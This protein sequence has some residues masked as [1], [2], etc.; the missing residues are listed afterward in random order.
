MSRTYTKPSAT[1]LSRKKSPTYQIEESSA[2]L[3]DFPLDSPVT[4][5]AHIATWVLYFGYLAWR[6][7]LIWELYVPNTVTWS[8]LWLNVLMEV[9]NI[10]SDF[11]SRFEIL[12]YIP[13]GRR[14]A[15]R[16]SYYL[17]GDIAPAVDICITCCGEDLDVIMDTVAGAA[18][19]SY[20]R[21]RFRVFLLDDAKS[22]A[23]ETAV[24]EFNNQ[25]PNGFQ[26][27]IYLA[28]KKQQGAPHHY[29]AGN[30][31]Y[32]LSES[33]RRGGGAEF[34]AALDV[35]MI[36]VKDWLRRVVP[37]LLLDQNVAMAIPP[38]RFYNTPKND[39]LGQDTNVFASLTEPMNDS[40]GGGWPLQNAGED[41]LC[42]WLLT[43]QGWDLTFVKDEVQFG[44]APDSLA[45]WFK[46]RARWTDGNIL[47]YRNLGWFLSNN[48]FGSRRTA[49]QRILGLCHIAKTYV[50][51]PNMFFIVLL[52]L[53][54][55]PV[56]WTGT[57]LPDSWRHNLG[58]SYLIFLLATLLQKFCYARIHS[59]VS[60][61]VA[62][63]HQAN[64]FWNTPLN[65]ARIIR[66]WIPG[67]I[68]SFEITGTVVSS[69]NER[70]ATHRKPLWT[71]LLNSMI[72]IPAVVVF[73]FSSVMKLSIPVQYM[74]WPP[75]VPERRQL[76]N[77]DVDGAYRAP[78][79]KKKNKCANGKYLIMFDRVQDVYRML[80]AAVDVLGFHTGKTPMKYAQRVAID[81][82]KC[83]VVWTALGAALPV[84][85]LWTLFL[86]AERKPMKRE[87][88][89]QLSMW[90]LNLLECLFCYSG[91]PDTAG[92]STDLPGSA[93][94]LVTAI[95]IG[96]DCYRQRRSG[97]FH[98]Q[99]LLL[100]QLQVITAIGGVYCNWRF[101][102][103]S[104]GASR[105][106]QKVDQEET[107]SFFSKMS[108][109]WASP[110][111][112]NSNEKGLLEMQDLPHLRDE[113]SAGS[114]K[115]DFLIEQRNFALRKRWPFV[116][117]LWNLTYKSLPGQ[118]LMGIMITALSFAPQA[119]LFGL[120][121]SLNSSWTVSWAYVLGLCLPLVLSAILDN[122]R[123]WISYRC[124]SL[125][126]QQHLMVALFDKAT[127]LDLASPTD[128]SM[129]KKTAARNTADPSSLMTLMSV[130]LKRVSDL[131]LNSYA[132]FETPIRLLVSA[133][134]LTRL[135]GWQSLL[136]SVIIV[137]LLW[138]LNK[139]TV[140]RYTCA[141]KTMM[142]YRDRKMASV[143]E[144]LHGIRQIKVSAMEE[145]WEDKI[146]L[147]REGELEA[148]RVTF[149]WNLVLMALYLL[150]PTVLSTVVLTMHSV[151]HGSLSPA[152]AFTVMSVLNTMQ[153]SLT[154]MPGIISSG[155]NC[156][157]S[158]KRLSEYLTTPEQLSVV[159]PSEN[160]EF[161]D[162][163]LA[164]HGHTDGKVAVLRN[165][166][167]KIPKH[168]MSVI[169][170]PTSA[171]KSLL[172]A[173]ILGE[174]DILSGTVRAP[175]RREWNPTFQR[176]Q[177]WLVEGAIAYV[178]QTPWIE[179]TTIKDNILFGLPYNPERYDQ[180]VAA[181]ALDHDLQSFPD[182]DRTQLG[183]NGVNLSGGQKSRLC[184][185]RALYSRATVLLLDD[186]LSAVDVHTAA[187][188]CKHALTGPLAQR[189]TCV[190][191]T[192][193]VS[194][195]LNYATCVMHIGEGSVCYSGATNVRE[196]GKENNR[197]PLS[198][199]LASS[200]VKDASKD[201]NKTLKA[202]GLTQAPGKRFTHDEFRATG[203]VQ[204]G[205]LQDYIQ[206]SGTLVYWLLLILG[207]LSYSGLMLSRAWWLGVWSQSYESPSTTE[208]DQFRYHAQIYIILSVLVCVVGSLRSYFAVL[209]SMK[210]SHSLFRRFLHQ[211]LRTPLRWIDTVP[212]GRVLNRFSNDFSLVDT[213]LG[214]D[215]RAILSYSM[216]VL[217]A[218]VPGL[219]VNPL[220][221]VSSGILGAITTRYA[222][223]YLVGARELKRL[224]SV[225]RSPIYEHIESS[226]AGLW[227][228]RAFGKTGVYQEQFRQKLDRRARTQWHSWMFN[229]WLAFRLDLIGAIFTA[230]SAAA[231]VMLAVDA[232]TAGFTISFTMRLTQS[233]SMGIRRYASLE[234]DLSSV[235]RILEY[236]NLEIEDNS[237]H[238]APVDWP[239]EGV[240]EVKNLTVRYA[241]G[242]FPA[243]QNVSFR[244]TRNQRVGVVGR[245]GAGKSSLA[246]V[247]FRILDASEGQILID[248]VDISDIRL[249]DVRKRLA[250][251]PQFPFIFRGTLRSNLD[252]F[253]NC[254]D[255]E[256]LSA[257]SRVHWSKANIS[258]DQAIDKPVSQGGTRKEKKSDDDTSVLDSPVADGGS[259]LSYGQRQLLC[260]AR[261]LIQMPRLL[262]LDEATS[263]V[264]KTT[265]SVVQQSIRSEFGRN[266]STLLVIA[267]RLSTVADFD[268]ILVLGGGKVLEFGQPV[269]LMRRDNGVFRSMVEEDAEKDSIVRGILSTGQSPLHPD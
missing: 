88:G 8:F 75:T 203:S 264:D 202:R 42:A 159:L 13:F 108:F 142:E 214:D 56:E 183:P 113:Y 94:R 259:N 58:Q 170:G 98:H 252:P 24:R 180:V 115:G 217:M 9:I 44:L 205:I 157:F 101:N 5:G 103:G 37:H 57:E 179:A 74:A 155:L 226:L 111:L 156:I 152:T 201:E 227:T 255:A 169:A 46:Q 141:N 36:P 18:S 199:I 78:E 22:S 10:L 181:C 123:Y 267:H 45:A 28:R 64:R 43:S 102:P 219:V 216:E 62:K 212:V 161:H 60:V 73:L 194:L 83:N 158:S 99:R 190:L 145:Q 54:L 186:I 215:V 16:P 257:L 55:Y 21:D 1:S 23:L 105:K 38:Q 48:D 11:V 82:R 189:R 147:L 128:L 241:P 168:G 120:L 172:L 222:K 112:Q 95:V 248:G 61:K 97:S 149:Q 242:I 230:I 266:D 232:S 236:C 249:H 114:M 174:C 122:R 100:S 237:G 117:A 253:G 137:M 247:L 182:G 17:H 200:D 49:L 197:M 195:C 258:E 110:L 208:S 124:L 132:I 209:G 234:L 66:S 251:I 244:V 213:Q 89:L 118:I 188:L 196:S 204:W 76:L 20:P 151:V 220:F 245:T 19:Q 261:A 79:V 31:R 15:H 198:S 265:D 119:A 27:V 160:I 50:A 148:Q 176:G 30:L 246:L 210:A 177:E 133:A 2:S 41:I 67:N 178:S 165:V 239:Q 231:V 175:T 218:V 140:K 86:D 254:E 135:V 65:T 207:F 235:E 47:S 96:I 59:G 121:D 263:A 80:L 228:I 51:L 134:M 25:R 6:V 106:D 77:K 7:K 173:A 125:R 12:L 166:N 35:D 14:P 26:N 90:T 33:A 92:L 243:L 262:I 185:A 240:L 71:R 221:L 187:H 129:E 72:L 81:G 163:S 69:I 127:R 144:A 162:A 130:D 250:M 87:I 223:W 107:S 224:D 126:V 268:Q 269:E 225:A 138:P 68:V 143:T 153:S 4:A 211:V 256:L 104:K 229:Q 109:S 139:Y 206:Q 29:K 191:V 131:M 53:A 39:M 3:E 91:R 34:V 93:G 154:A 150:T 52:P 136:A 32:G 164:W 116:S 260:L 184:L 84:V 70:S 193:H 40:L 63:N 171:G 238:P 146:N 85:S 233:I 167:L 192:H